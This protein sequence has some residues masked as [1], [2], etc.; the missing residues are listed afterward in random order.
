MSPRYR[1]EVVRRLRY[2]SLPRFLELQREKNALLVAA[3][4]TP[5]SVRC[6]AF[7]GLHHL[8]LEAEFTS[9][10]AFEQES[11]RLGSVDGLA[12]LDAEQLSLVEQGG[13]ED[14][15]SKLLL[16]PGEGS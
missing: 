7:G 11:G 14:R 12:A 16:D 5:Y 13:A 8:T 4:C 6:P 1:R 2:G 9:L 15:I 3:G 10:S